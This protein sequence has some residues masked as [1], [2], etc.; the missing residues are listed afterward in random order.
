MMNLIIGSTNRFNLLTVPLNCKS[1]A[2]EGHPFSVGIVKVKDEL[3]LRVSMSMSMMSAYAVMFVED[4]ILRD[5]SIFVGI[6]L[7]H[8]GAFCPLFVVDLTIAN[9][10]LW[11]LPTM[12][13]TLEDLPTLS[14]IVAFLK[15]SVYNQVLLAPM[16]AG[17]PQETDIGDSCP[18]T[19]RCSSTC[20]RDLVL[21]DFGHQGKG[22]LINVV[23][24][25]S[26]FFDDLSIPDDFKAA[27]GE[28]LPFSG[29]IVKTKLEGITEGPLMSFMDGGAHAEYKDKSKDN[30]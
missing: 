20:E 8:I 24:G 19:I 13:L 18:K 30:G 22:Q 26:Y 2:I 11:A 29:S 3:A 7:T 27:G 4:E 23:V 28:R 9:L 5:L 15:V 14:Q 10:D 1:L 21:P 25:R 6:Q 12:E 16:A 17:R